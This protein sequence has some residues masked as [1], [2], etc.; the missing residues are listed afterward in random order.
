MSAEQS[1]LTELGLATAPSPGEFPFECELSLAPLIAFWE[2]VT[3]REGSGKGVLG[4]ALQARLRDVPEL[5]RPIQ[6]LSIL[7]AQRDIV[8]TLMTAIFPPAFWDREIGAACLPFRLQRFYAT[9]SFEHTLM[10]LDGTIQGRHSADIRSALTRRL[11]AAYALVLRRVYDIPVEVEYPLV[12]TVTDQETGL[13]RHFKMH[14]DWDFLAVEPVGE[15][16]PLPPEARQRFHG[17]FPDLETLKTLL[18]A[19]RFRFRGFT[20]F[21]AIEV[22]DQEV[23]S[24]LK[25]DLIDKESLISRLRL[26]GL[27][28]RLRTLFRRPDLRFGLAALSGGQV[29]ALRAGGT[30]EHRCIFADS[31]HHELADLAGSLYEQAIRQGRPQLAEDLAAQPQRTGVE[32]GLLRSGIRN[33]VVAPLVYGE[34]V[35]GC[36]DLGSPQPG[37]L[38]SAVHGP[39]LQEVLPLFAMAV[40][41]SMEELNTRIQAAIK[42]RC[43]AIHPVVEWRFRQAVMKRMKRKGPAPEAAPADLEPIVF[44]DVYPLYALAD[45]R[46]S[47]TRRAE[48]MQADLLA[49]LALA[50]EV[51]LAAYA[52]RPL[53][54][55]PFL[56]QRLDRKTAQI[57]GSLRSGDELSVLAFLRRDIE[58]L[59][60]AFQGFGPVV[61]QSI[62]AYRAPLDP[63]HGAVYRRRQA[64]EESVALVNETISTYLDAEEEAAQAMFPHYFS[65]RRT[66][67]V[68]YSIYVGASLL[69]HGGFHP[70]Y[71]KNLRLWQLLVAC[72]IGRR[73]EGVK[74]RLPVPLEIT[75]LILV[76]TAPLALRFRLDEKLFDV[77]GAYD[78]RYEIIKK[79]IDK[80]VVRG[81][82]ER[83]TQPGKVAVVYSQPSEATEYREYLAFLQRQGSLTGAVEDLELEELQGVPGLRALRVAVD[84]AGAPEATAP[85]LAAATAE[86]SASEA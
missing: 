38:N 33:L 70:L 29:L 61:R 83:L 43:T 6:D 64:F 57:A 21:R 60:E 69:E 77:D 65:K 19:D 22:T 41:R 12:I 74:A 81:T 82:Q 48:A 51:L 9:P 32:D 79:R 49:Q 25:R 14:L 58:P 36:L 76:H 59:F 54:I 86:A 30:T 8:E 15:V 72:G 13:E 1:A 71:L 78:L 18:P 39:R 16:P 11:L 24:A 7:T 42:E 75:N 63:Q 67:G 66:D 28:D 45:I 56:T 27:Q 55:L 62:A 5:A 10:A 52:A 80:A 53:P 35:I 37:A 40:K 20:V 68:D 17:S 46:G 47:S 23:L 34:A 2:E 31:T 50:R 73:V 3:A 26:D 44:P 85:L 84:L 4:Q